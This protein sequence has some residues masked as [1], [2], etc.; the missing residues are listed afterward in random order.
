MRTTKRW[1]IKTLSLVLLLAAVMNIASCG[2]SADKKAL[3]GT[4]QYDGKYGNVTTMTFNADGSWS[5]FVGYDYGTKGTNYTGKYYVDDDEKTI[6]IEIDPL[7]DD[8]QF[9]MEVFYHYLLIG[10]SLTLSG[11]FD[12][13]ETAETYRKIST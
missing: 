11:T 1:H 3:I 2:G 4:W 5:S 9:T 13:A 7:P 6:T 10:D 12:T 8:L